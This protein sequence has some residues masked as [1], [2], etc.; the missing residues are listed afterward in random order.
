MANLTLTFRSPNSSMTIVTLWNEKGEKVEKFECVAP[1]GGLVGAL[2]MAADY[3]AEN[4][5][6]IV[7]LPDLSRLLAKSEA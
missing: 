3:A 7:N 1:S 5:A 2:A 4:N 6:K